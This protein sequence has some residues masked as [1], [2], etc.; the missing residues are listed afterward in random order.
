MALTCASSCSLEAIA[1]FGP[2]VAVSTSVEFEVEGLPMTIGSRD[3]ATG[4]GTPADVSS[5]TT[6]VVKSDGL[7]LDLIGAD[8]SRYQSQYNLSEGIR[9]KTYSRE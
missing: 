1:D 8:Y 9:H 3:E 4:A 5:A 2:A 7:R 6:E